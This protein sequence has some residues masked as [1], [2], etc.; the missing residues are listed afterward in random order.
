MTHFCSR[1]LLLSTLLQILLLGA[2]IA[3]S[4]TTPANERNDLDRGLIEA[5]IRNQD[6][7]AYSYRRVSNPLTPFITASVGTVGTLLGA[8]LAYLGLQGQA[9]KQAELE[10]T[11]WGRAQADEE[12]RRKAEEKRDEHKEARLATADLAKKV[13]VAAHYITWILWVARY[14]PERFTRALVDEH[15]RRMIVAYADIVAA[16]VLSAALD[17]GIYAKSISLIQKVYDLDGELGKLAKDIPQSTGSIGLL[18]E[19]ARDLEGEIPNAFLGILHER[20]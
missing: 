10:D 14:D 16:Q 17:E 7:Q 19:W 11:R 13:A 8:G 1:V 6:A 12:A 20:V 5:Q 18:W 15:D 3:Q 4:T 2:A 9:K